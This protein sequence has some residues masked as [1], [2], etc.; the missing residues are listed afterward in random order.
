VRIPSRELLLDMK[1]VRKEA[2]KEQAVTEPKDRNRISE[3]M[4]ESVRDELEAMRR[5]K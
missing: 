1:R 3:H 2:A 5:G 4:K